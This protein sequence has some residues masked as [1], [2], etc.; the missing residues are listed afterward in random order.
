MVLGNRLELFG[1]SDPTKGDG[2]IRTIFQD[3]NEQYQTGSW[4]I[5]E[6]GSASFDNIVANNVRI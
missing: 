4:I 1:G 5:R 6:N 2:Y 3:E